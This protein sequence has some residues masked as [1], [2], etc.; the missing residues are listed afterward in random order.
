MYALFKEQPDGHVAQVEQEEFDSAWADFGQQHSA[1]KAAS[2]SNHPYH[3]HPNNPYDGNPDAITIA[4]QAFKGGSLQDACLALEAAVKANPGVH[5]LF[6]SMLVLCIPCGGQYN[7][8]SRGY[9]YPTN[10]NFLHWVI[11]L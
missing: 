11:F 2:S 9:W 8:T 4:Q 3:F 1:S 10:R 7:R 5:S 6:D